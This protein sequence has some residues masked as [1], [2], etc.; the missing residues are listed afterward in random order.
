MTYAAFAT[1]NASFQNDTF[2]HQML[3]YDGED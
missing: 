3:H 2:G 1:A